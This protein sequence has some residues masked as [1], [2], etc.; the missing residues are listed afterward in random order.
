[1]FQNFKSNK[2]DNINGQALTNGQGHLKGSFCHD[3]RIMKNGSSSNSSEF[4]DW[5]NIALSHFNVDLLIV[6]LYISPPFTILSISISAWFLQWKFLLHLVS[7]D[8]FYVLFTSR[9]N[10]LWKIGYYNKYVFGGA[11]WLIGYKM[12]ISGWVGKYVRKVAVTRSACY[13]YE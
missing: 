9:C 11:D 10:F 4:I 3:E 1:M 5:K 12:T 8:C 13:N 6:I 2:M 7:I